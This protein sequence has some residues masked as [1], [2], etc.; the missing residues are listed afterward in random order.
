M[1]RDEQI[2]LDEC[3]LTVVLGTPGPAIAA[4]VEML[5]AITRAARQDSVVVEVDSLQDWEAACAAG[6]PFIAVSQYPSPDLLRDLEFCRTPAIMVVAD[7]MRSV[8]HLL[9]ER[10]SDIGAVRSVSASIACLLDRWTLDETEA[11]A[12]NAPGFALFLARL[13][14][15]S[16]VN[17]SFSDIE[18]IELQAGELADRLVDIGTQKQTAPLPANSLW[19][20]AAAALPRLCDPRRGDS[21]IQT[22]WLGPLF[23]L[24]DCPD[25]WMRGPVDLSGPARCVLYGP[26]LHLPPGRWS[27]RLVLGLAGHDGT[28]SFTVEIVCGE[29]IAKGSFS[30]QGSG[31]FE[32][33]MDFTHRD[34]QIPIEFRLFLDAGAIYGWL[35]RFEV[36]LE[37]CERI[38]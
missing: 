6:H 13:A 38:G 17:V 9:E 15:S 35:S 31:L 32:V 23:L 4:V 34:P 10:L 29:V 20:L 37:L 22:M 36:G 33:R 21:R 11:R 30:A 12:Q 2:A 18:R 8:A 7:P 3:A 14:E 27:A 24:G 1:T 28:E 25:T 19:A 16:G 5:Q 26:Y